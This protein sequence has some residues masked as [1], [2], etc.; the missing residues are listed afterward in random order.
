MQQPIRVMIVDDSALMREMLSAC[1]AMDPELEV[2]AMAEH[3]LEAREKIRQLSPDVLTLDVEMP[4]MDGIS[5]LEKIMRL[6]P[7]PV[8]MVST[9]TTRGAQTTLDALELGAVDY[10][11]K[12]QGALA[13]SQQQA[14]AQEL[15]QK[16]KAAAKARLRPFAVSVPTVRSAPPA[17]RRASTLRLVAIGA[18][19]GGVEALRAILSQLPAGLPPLVITQH[20]PASFTASFAQRLSQIAPFPVVEATDQHILQ[21]G[22]GYLAPGGLQ[23][24]VVRHASGLML[25]V[26]PGE[27]VSGHCPSVDVLF[28]SVA[29]S[30]GKQAL[31]V[32]L[33]GMG[34]DG[35]AGLLAMR[36]QEAPTLG[37]DEA[38]CVV[39][40]MPQV[41]WKLGAVQ[42]QI[43][44]QEMPKAMMEALYPIHSPATRTPY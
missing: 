39:Y 11:A 19:T 27:P 33:T 25:R 30:V 41:A 44:L 37:Q 10:I 18:S 7:M 4:H 6:R 14:F 32:I 8:V 23:M 31:G 43:S 21:P 36:Q 3:P 34:K 2:I 17:M 1:I 12:P 42:K 29:Q 15:C 20:M 22:H 13:T 9:L 35:A 26:Q 24:R 28:H 40:G 38:S 16:L 5:F